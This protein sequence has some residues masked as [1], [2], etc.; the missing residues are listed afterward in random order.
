MQNPIRMFHIG[1]LLPALLALSLPAPARAA[2]SAFSPDGRHV[3]IADGT[4]TDLD[5]QSGRA[6]PV[7][8]PQEVT[9]QKV[10][11]I[12][13]TG[14]GAG[15]L[16][17][18]TPRWLIEFTPATRQFKALPA[19]PGAGLDFTDLAW[20]PADGYLYLTATSP[21]ASA[22]PPRCELLCLVTATHKLV[23]VKMRRVD[24]LQA[25]VFDARGHFFYSVHGD[26][27]E[28]GLEYDETPLHAEAPAGQKPVTFKMPTWLTGERVAPLAR[29]ETQVGNSGSTGV[30][31]IA[32]ATDGLIIH[33]KRIGGSGWGKILRLATPEAEAE[34]KDGEY[35]DFL[36]ILASARIIGENGTLAQL[37]ASPD[38]SKVFY[39][40]HAWVGGKPA[41]AQNYWLIENGGEPKKIT[42]Q[43][44]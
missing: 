38:G 44:R 33:T 34:R 10:D 12:A 5:L 26:L 19:E 7:A 43:T 18:L 21:M 16:A 2:Q 13:I 39:R 24:W 9:G 35:Q 27:W 1:F 32:P 41:D 20:N 15:R 4:L 29:L 30:Y 40:A 37:C 8:I 6:T 17:L 31:E 22:T 23:P 36:R 28:G 25:P 3:Y 11:V 42:A 14:A